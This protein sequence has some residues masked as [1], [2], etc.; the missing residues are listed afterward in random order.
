[1]IRFP[2]GEIEVS[3]A[4]VLGTVLRDIKAPNGIKS[5]VHLEAKQRVINHKSL[6]KEIRKYI[7]LQLTNSTPPLLVS[8]TI[9]SGTSHRSELY[10]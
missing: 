9:V 3:D 10:R 4:T 7:N 5:L 8:F 1:M 6:K 2:F